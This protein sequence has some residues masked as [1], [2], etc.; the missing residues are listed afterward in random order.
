[1]TKAAAFLDDMI[2]MQ[3]KKKEAGASDRVR[4]NEFFAA[5]QY[6][7]AMEAYTIAL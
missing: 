3:I 7:E 5:G 4:G 6:D 1:M 2:S